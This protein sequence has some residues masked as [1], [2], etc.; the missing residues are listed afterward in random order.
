VGWCGS[1]GSSGV[2]HH[3][4]PSRGTTEEGG[5]DGRGEGG[6]ASFSPWACAC[7]AE[8]CMTEV[9]EVKNLCPFQLRCVCSR[10]H[11][12]PLPTA[13]PPTATPRIC[14]L[15]TAFHRLVPCFLRSSPST[16]SHAHARLFSRL[17]LSSASGRAEKKGIQSERVLSGPHRRCFDALG[18]RTVATARHPRGA[19]ARQL[20]L[21]TRADGGLT[22]CVGGSSTGAKRGA[23]AVYCLCDRRAPR[24][25]PAKYVPQVRQFAPLQTLT[26]SG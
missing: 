6:G 4:E 18:F 25:L 23:R 20:A 2:M 14:A 11:G 13:L 15:L 19:R 21:H 24:Q 10:A 9:V 12:R 7:G 26:L 5:G 16:R 17:S 3:R 1:D 22:R 8:R